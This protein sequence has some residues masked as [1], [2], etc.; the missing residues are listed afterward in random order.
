MLCIFLSL[1]EEAVSIHLDLQSRQSLGIHWG[2]FKLTYEHYLAPRTQA[3]LAAQERG[4]RSEEF[5][6]L[7]LGESVEGR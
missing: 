7:D 3:R 2:T 5:A 4:L 6:V 1:I